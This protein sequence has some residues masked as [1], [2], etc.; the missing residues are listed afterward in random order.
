MNGC[1]SC[2]FVSFSSNAVIALAIVPRNA[3]TFCCATN[4]R[5]LVTDNGGVNDNGVGS[6]T[7]AQHKLN[8]R[9]GILEA[10]GSCW[11]VRRK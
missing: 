6:S 8:C 1:A 7:R 3:G 4:W 11:T 2:R 9:E 10:Q 5:G